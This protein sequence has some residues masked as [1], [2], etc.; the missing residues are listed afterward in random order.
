M[1]LPALPEQ[2]VAAEG[3][4]GDLNHFVW[5]KEDGRPKHPQPVGNDAKYILTRSPSRQEAVV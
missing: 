3:G 4:H 1:Y 5:F 2:V